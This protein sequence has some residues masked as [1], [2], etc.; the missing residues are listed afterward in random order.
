MTQL[1]WPYPSRDGVQLHRVD[2]GWD[3]QAPVGTPVLAVASGTIGYAH[4]PAGFG[5]PYP[6][7]FLDD[8][9]PHGRAVYYGHQHPEV[10]AG[11]RV[12]VG[13]VIAHASQ[14]P[15]G[16]ANG[17][18]GW[19]EV[20]WWN[21]GPTGDGSAMQAA[22]QSAPLYQPPGGLL[23]V[24]PPTVQ[25]DATGKAVTN[26]QALLNTFNANLTVDGH[27]GPATDQ[28]V[29]NFQKVTGQVVDGIVGPKTW[30]LLVT[31]ET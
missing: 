26:A 15:G 22:L 20:G 8:P 27:F 31:L 14:T 24:M 9:D 7:L 30:T 23:D 28:A 29:R 21:E 25:Q 11:A 12:T 16:N 5:D 1:V 18:P 10:A 6:V 19:L 13:Q 2:Q 3:L 17:L 4:D